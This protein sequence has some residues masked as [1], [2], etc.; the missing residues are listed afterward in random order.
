MYP[1]A[2]DAAPSRLLL[3]SLCE[4]DATVCIQSSYLPQR[5]FANLEEDVE[6][7]DAWEIASRRASVISRRPSGHSI[8]IHPSSE[9]ANE[10]VV[11]EPSTAIGLGG[12]PASLN[13]LLAGNGEDEGS[14]TNDSEGEPGDRTMTRVERPVM[15]ERQDTVVPDRRY[16][17]VVDSEETES[18][19]VPTLESSTT[20]FG[21]DPAIRQ[22]LNAIS[23]PSA[24][25]LE[26]ANPVNIG[27]SGNVGGGVDFGLGETPRNDTFLATLAPG[28]HQR[29]DLASRIE[30]LGRD[31]E[32]VPEEEGEEGWM[33]VG[34]RS[35]EEGRRSG[36]Q[37]RNG[38]Y[39]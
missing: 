33:D 39:T 34:R 29:L 22:A 8:R 1:T 4:L 10:P 31:V 14:G 13:E 27:G 30:R 35:G 36:D 21:E 24:L 28:V 16:R 20:L 38:L 12:T 25:N 6:T 5:T 11:G 19:T 3:S 23:A 9:R 37:E 17:D 26:L 32:A 18:S 7:E 2:S 15:V